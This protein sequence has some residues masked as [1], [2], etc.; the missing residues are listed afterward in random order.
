VT[1]AVSQ[2]AERI[3]AVGRH[4]TND[5]EPL[6]VQA[7]SIASD[8]SQDLLTRALAH[9][10][11]GNASRLLNKFE[12]ACDHYAKAVQ[13]LEAVDQPVELARTLHAG[14]VPLF[15]LGRF[16]ELF[17]TADRARSLF[18]D[19]GDCRGIA[20]LNVN[21]AH[22][23]H[24]LD[25]HR[26]ALK[27]SETAVMILEKIGDAEGFVAASINSATTL[28]IMHE[29]ERARERYVKAQQTASEHDLWSSAL[30][31]RHNLAYLRYLDGQTGS[32]LQDYAQLHS[33]Y[34]K[35]NDEWQLCRC[36]LDEAEIFL[37][38]GDLD[39]AVRA[40]QESR[41]LATKLNLNL[42]IGKASLF[43][44]ASRI[45]LETPEAA[46]PL[47]AEATRRFEREGNTVWTAASHLQTAL[48]SEDHDAANA[49]SRAMAAL[50]LLRGKE[51]PHRLAMANIVVGRM[52]R[53]LGDYASAI[54]SFRDGLDSARQ[55]NSQWMQFHALHQLG[56]SLAKLDPHCSQ[57]LLE[58]A[59]RLLD[60]LWRQLGS[61]DLKLAFLA[62]RDNVYTHLV[63]HAAA[64][65]TRAFELSEKA[66]SRVLR[67][68]LADAA[69]SWSSADVRSRLTENESIIE[70]FIS[71]DD[72]FVFTVNSDSLKCDIRKGA[73]SKLQTASHNLD[74]H[75]AS[76]SVKWERLGAAQHHFEATAREHLRELYDE[77]IHPYI[78]DLRQKVVIVPHGFLHNLPFH[79]FF[80]GNSFLSEQR[81]VVYSPSAVLYCSEASPVD[82]ADPL[83]LAF[84]SPSEALYKGVVNEVNDCAAT[85]SDAAVLVNPSFAALKDA[86]SVPRRHLHIAGHAGIDNVGGKLSWIETPAGRLT[87][88]ELSEMHIRAQTIV[89]TGCQT[90]RRVIR[91]GDEWLGM[92]RAFY[93]AG[94]GT[95]ISTFWDVRDES[96]R[97]FASEF[98]RTYNGSNAA[99]ATRSA[100]QCLKEW[101][102][103]PYFWAGFAVFVRRTNE[104]NHR[105]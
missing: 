8:Q 47:L 96:A 6:L 35:L 1:S 84:S 10:A 16:E 21:L 72:L 95:I 57:I 3:K 104:R 94:A 102:S 70:F 100:S 11:A 52:L 67:E 82:Y 49:L 78:A 18:E 74:R 86:L 60:S 26:E 69:P 15:F 31:C 85:F 58:E 19:A 89:I 98:Y 22:A 76:C 41:L 39:E 36:L 42:E 55:S 32:A 56:S 83:F 9:R 54:E 4:S 101:K 7:E 48:L 37:E 105:Y 71:G 91:P 45:R 73:V 50:D 68:Q 46:A 75:M 63:R 40:A 25:R 2:L 92:M 20:R 64:S 44:A 62:D 17:H 5:V 59:D 93:A 79:A 27:C 28:T 81:D 97:R 12:P 90:A 61:D 14:L 30:L 23:Y 24:R 34:R 33:E 53:A 13:F 103:H 77:L 43:E 88:R 51:L 29:F 87:S 65:P 66:R 38:I 80:D 99:A